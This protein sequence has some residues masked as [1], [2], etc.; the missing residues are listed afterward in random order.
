M[1]SRPYVARFGSNF[2]RWT[3][4]V[5]ATCHAKFIRIRW[6]L[7]NLWEKTAKKKTQKWPK[8]QFFDFWD[9]RVRLPG[10]PIF[11]LLASL[12]SHGHGEMRGIFGEYFLYQSQFRLAV[13]PHILRRPP[14]FTNSGRRFV[15]DVGNSPKF[16]TFGRTNVPIT[17]SSHLLRAFCVKIGWIRPPNFKW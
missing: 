13:C 5:V 12:G 9:N 17:R 14:R 11:G 15:I 16:D 6:C 1:I 3:G 4:K 10:G 7:W 2:M 8:N